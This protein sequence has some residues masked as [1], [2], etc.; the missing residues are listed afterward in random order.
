M[1]ILAWLAKSIAGQLPPAALQAGLFGLCA[2]VLALPARQG[3]G[4][5]G[6]HDIAT[7]TRVI[8][9]S[10]VS[11]SGRTRAATPPPLEQATGTRI[12]PYEVLSAVGTTDTQRVLLGWDPR[13]KRSVWIRVMTPGVPGVSSVVRNVSRSTRLHWLQGRRTE[14]GAWDAYESLDGQPLLAAT[15]VQ[16]WR[17]VSIWLRDLAH[18]LALG[19]TEGS[20]D[21]LALDR[22]WI[23]A[24]GRAKLLDFRAPGVTDGE[25]TPILFDAASTQQFLYAAARRALSSAVPPLP[26]SVSAF[27]D[28]LQRGQFST[29]SE[30]EPR[31]AELQNKPDRV[32]SS[33]RG[34]TL[35]LGVVVYLLG[36][37]AI[38]GLLANSVFPLLPADLASR[39]S[40]TVGGAGLIGSAV[41]ALFWAGVCRSGAWLRAFGVAVVTPDG[42]E[43][44]RLRA[45]WRAAVAWS[46]VPLQLL[47]VAYGGPLL[48]IAAAKLVGLFYAA[49]H[50]ERGIQDRLAGTYLVPR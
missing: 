34:M 5:Y 8:T 40:L 31:L 17:S 20:I 3:N 15:N 43:A 18:E 48:L 28:A 2:G 33:S 11:E 13:L 42:K 47:F 23:T 25:S 6:L 38:G 44:S 46:W 32:T 41:L 35:G 9:R 22:V 27:L 37:D 14:S 36:S 21:V 49:D 24:S 29:L 10:A 45:V 19:T 26:L 4:F 7:G 30:I 12:G 16:S 1:V 50:P 39:F